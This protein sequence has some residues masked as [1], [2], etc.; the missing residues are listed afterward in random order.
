MKTSYSNYYP[1]LLVALFTA[2]ANANA[3]VIGTNAAA[4]AD[5]QKYKVVGTSLVPDNTA[6]LSSVLTGNAAAPGGNVE[7]FK[8]SE[9]LTNAAYASYGQTTS[10]V[11]DL[12]GSTLTFSSLNASD[13]STIVAPG[14]TLLQQWTSDLFTAYSL[15][16][17][18]AA[19]FDALFLTNGGEQRFSDPNI[20][21]AYSQNGQIHLGLAGF[22]DAS[23]LLSP[24]LGSALPSG[25]IQLSELVKVSYNGNTSY[26]YGFNAT[27][28]GLKSNDPTNSFTGNYDLTSTDPI[29][30]GNQL[31][32]FTVPEPST[33]LLIGA[34]FLALMTQLRRRFL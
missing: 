22:Y 4:A 11:G 25:L 14:T 32:A 10:L 16:A 34:G 31:V 19:A 17:A 8:S 5:F 30:S 21:Y 18:N 1:V 7:L 3:G 6:N 26:L 27:P 28:S 12:G 15:P 23:S 29:H 13:W 20:S 9:T 2:S 33:T 24:L